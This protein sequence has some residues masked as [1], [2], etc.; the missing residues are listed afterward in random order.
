[1]GILLKHCCSSQRLLLPIVGSGLLLYVVAMDVDAASRFGVG[2]IDVHGT[3]HAITTW[4][5]LPIGHFDDNGQDTKVLLNQ[6]VPTS[7][8]SQVETEFTGFPT[9]T[10]EMDIKAPFKME[11]GVGLPA[12]SDPT[13]EDVFNPFKIDDYRAIYSTANEA[14]D[15]RWINK[16]DWTFSYPQ[17]DKLIQELLERMSRVSGKH[18]IASPSSCILNPTEIQWLFSVR[19]DFPSSLFEEYVKSLQQLPIRLRVQTVS[20]DMVAASPESF[21]SAL[22]AASTVSGITIGGV[23]VSNLKDGV[24]AVRNM[25]FSPDCRRYLYHSG[26]LSTQRHFFVDEVNDND[27]LLLQNS[28]DA[29]SQTITILPEEESGLISTSDIAKKFEAWRKT[30]VATTEADLDEF[31]LLSGGS[32]TELDKYG[33]WVFGYTDNNTSN[34]TINSTSPVVRYHANRLISNFLGYARARNSFDYERPWVTVRFLSDMIEI[35]GR[36]Q[37]K[38]N[39][40][41]E[42][43]PAPW[44]DKFSQRRDYIHK[45]ASDMN[46]GYGSFSVCVLQENGLPES[47]CQYGAALKNEQFAKDDAMIEKR[48]HDYEERDFALYNIVVDSLLQWL[49]DE[50]IR[51]ELQ[52]DLL[53]LKTAVDATIELRKRAHEIAFGSIP[54]RLVENKMP[55]NKTIE[56]GTSI[57]TIVP[58]FREAILLQVN[59]SDP[60][61][62]AIKVGSVV[63]VKVLK[64]SQ[65]PIPYEVISL[66]DVSDSLQ[67]S[68]ENLKKYTGEWIGRQ[69]YTGTVTA[70]ASTTSGFSIEVV[71]ECDKNQYLFAE[72]DEAELPFAF[73]D[74]LQKIFPIASERINGT[75]F[76]QKKLITRRVPDGLFTGAGEL[77][78]LLVPNGQADLAAY[79]NAIHQRIVGQQ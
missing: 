70:I 7:L 69:E 50:K 73:K 43:N 33:S 14:G 26:I 55:K 49:Q 64:A 78:V 44:E 34:Y 17:L 65:P 8:N 41:R 58:A 76:L 53:E 36:S 45:A 35:V 12:V 61:M 42:I 59:S 20:A 1:M 18:Q 6:I 13:S 51:F 48:A 38:V 39:Y 5:S 32:S 15:P 46:M 10:L 27:L 52:P 47:A 2:T 3:D 11:T 79:K 66:T 56:Q 19:S 71:L 9:R 37:R 63:D 72:V 28:W 62:D 24:T 54:F 30:Y 68:S 16:A 4:S 40:S 25:V 31:A 29:A 75:G 67:A 22:K 57:A 74:M 77:S 23:S 21:S 60:L